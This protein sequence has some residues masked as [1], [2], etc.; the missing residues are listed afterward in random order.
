MR[1]L[2]IIP[3]N[4][5]ESASGLE[6]I[7]IRLAGEFIQQGHDCQII[8]LGQSGIWETGVIIKGFTDIT[9]IGR[10]LLLESYSYDVIQ[11]MEIFPILEEAEYQYLLS[12]LLKRNFGKFVYLMVATPGNMEL[13]GGGMVWTKLLSKFVDG[14]IVYND[15]QVRELELCGIPSN[16]IHI[17]AA[18][19]DTK[20]MFRPPTVQEHNALREKHG[21]K[22]ETFYFLFI[23]RFVDR[24]RPDFLLKVWNSLFDLHERAELI[25]VG[26]G[27]NHPE[28]IDDVVHELARKTQSVKVLPYVTD[29]WQYY[30]ASNAFI[31]PSIRDGGP[32]V[33]WEAMS[34]EL[35]V[36]GSNISGVNSLISHEQNGILC[37]PNSQEDFA[38]AM[39]YLIN[40]HDQARE[41]GKKARQTIC[42]NRDI[43]FV[44]NNYLALYKGH[45]LNKA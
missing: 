7:S 34:C 2:L 5:F 11:W 36:I 40:N 6:L 30:A 3:Y 22:R 23:G 37:N 17:F 33:L 41:L 15:E 45:L 44:A 18:G 20:D 32:M 21:W 8:T 4:P 38:E 29:T 12:Y 25:L 42:N 27:L 28:A 26:S 43:H 19:I 1:I 13:R 31:V 39:R 35:P 14:F 9:A 16:M 24:K 10:W